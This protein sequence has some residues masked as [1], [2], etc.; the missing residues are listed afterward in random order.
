MHTS[1]SANPLRDFVDLNFARRL[2]AAETT[3]SAQLAGLQGY[4][5]EAACQ[6]FA[7]GVATFGGK[8]YPA[9]HIVGL[10]LYGPV[11]TVSLDQVEDFYRSRGVPCEIV[12]SPLADPSLRELLASRGYRITEFNSVMIQRL[13][14]LQFVD[15]A[16]GITLERVTPS[17]ERL[18]SDVVT[19]GFS[20]YG[21]LPENLLRPMATLPDAI[22]LL[23]RVEGV[24][25]GGGMA[26]VMRD[27]NIVALFGTATLPQFRRRGV[28][29]A[30]I[31]RRLWEAAQSGCEYA[32]V[33]TMPGSGSQRNMERHGF[34]VAYTKIVMVRSWP[35]LEAGGASDGH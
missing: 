35:G 24:V 2:E 17:T 32:V 3:T 31:Q 6:V 20:E 10:G 18:W 12:V 23:A 27:A 34:R 28:Q 5:P 19:E 15:P 11:T 1:R 14:D 8:T 29:R 13:E 4:W 25:A 22:N 9:N 30:L 7:G 21:P 26:Y 16:D 33:S